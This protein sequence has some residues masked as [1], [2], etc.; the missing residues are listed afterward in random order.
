MPVIE[1]NCNV[2]TGTGMSL[3][4]FQNKTQYPSLQI[5]TTAGL[6]NRFKTKINKT[7]TIS[8]EINKQ[9]NKYINKQ[10]QM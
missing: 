7:H 6:I 8:K 3:V 2:W 5:I 10:I 4:S 9:T 1:R